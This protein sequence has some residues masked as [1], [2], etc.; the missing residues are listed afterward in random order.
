VLVPKVVTM[1]KH[2][3]GA[4]FGAGRTVGAIVGVARETPAGTPAM[5]QCS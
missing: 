1:L 4:G 3:S 5:P 2:S